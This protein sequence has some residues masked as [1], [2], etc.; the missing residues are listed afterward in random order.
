M[1]ELIKNAMRGE[2]KAFIELMDSVSDRMY[3]TAWA[4]LK[5]DAD[6]A[7]AIQETILICWQKLKTLQK[8]Q[9]FRTWVTRILINECYQILKKKKRY[10]DTAEKAATVFPTFDSDAGNMRFKE[11][12]SFAD[13]KYHLLLTLYYADEYSVVEIA[14][15]L[16]LS[17][18][19]VKTRLAR[20][21]DQIRRTYYEDSKISYGS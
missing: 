17:T 18:G 19:A 13:E 7:D 2:E 15:M 14:D 1:E 6:V 20:A 16:G 3:R 11:L 8:P 5:Q 10:S 21:R 4:I 12:L 9:M